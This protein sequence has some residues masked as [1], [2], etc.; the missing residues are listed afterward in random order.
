MSNSIRACKRSLF[1]WLLF[2]LIIVVEDPLHAQTKQI[3]GRV[4]LEGQ[5]L[6]S[7]RVAWGAEDSFVETD[8][9]GV[10]H[11]ESVCGMIRLNVIHADCIPLDTVLFL[12][13]IGKAHLKLSRRPRIHDLPQALVI[14]AR[15]ENSFNLSGAGHTLTAEDIRRMNPLSANQ[16]LRAV[17]GLNIVDEEGLGL[18]PNIGFRGLDPDR[19]RY[20]LVL[21]DGIPVSLG[22]YNEPELYYTPPID[23]MVGVEVLKGSAALA[24]GPRTIAGVVNYRTEDPPSQAQG[25]VNFQC[26]GGGFASLLGTFGNTV[27]KTGF[28]VTIL[29]KQTDDFGMLRLRI[30]DLNAKARWVISS[31]GVAGMKIGLYDEMSNANYIG[32]TDP[33]FRAGGQDYARLAPDDRFKV[34][35]YSISGNYSYRFNEHLQADML[36]YAYTTRRNW[37][38]QDFTYSALDSLG[39]MLQ[40]PVDWSGVTWGDTAI[41][42]GAIHM[43]N[44]TGNRNRSYRVAGADLRLRYQLAVGSSRHHWSLGLKGVCERAHELRINGS[45][46]GDTGGLL[47]DE[48]YRP[49]L[50]LSAYLSDRIEWRNLEINPGIRIE[51]MVYKRRILRGVYVGQVVDT[52]IVGGGK[53]VEI[54]PGVSMVYKFHEKLRVYGGIHKGFAPPRVKDAISTSGTDEQLDAE[55]SINYEV[56]VRAQY[57]GLFSYDVTFFALE[58]SNQVIPTSESAGSGGGVGLVNGGGTRSR[59]VELSIALESVRLGLGQW[60]MSVRSALTFTD[61][62]FSEDRYSGSGDDRINLKGLYLPYAPRWSSNVRTDLLH[63][64]GWGLNFTSNLISAQFTDVRNTIEPAANGQ[65]G[66]L[67]G[68]QVFDAGVFR[69]WNKYAF[70][71]S[72]TIRNLLDMRYA[73]TRR[74]Q[75]TRVGLPR[76]VFLSLSKSF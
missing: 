50:G 63:G 72:L 34:R 70:N 4:D 57:G 62:R 41:S 60:S 68:Y 29:R 27:G 42:G 65:S 39:R 24:Q 8:S 14:G 11:I 10:F 48:E 61:A 67:K 38:R 55:K 2:F 15:R 45:F 23:R 69:Q 1:G 28:R 40:P 16:V 22:P 56:G 59:G 58:F 33:M 71:V 18:R 44:S 9:R 53:L 75:G 13:Q 49:V 30:H 73:Y 6:K 51:H 46:P 26:G 21:E 31:K 66:L 37:C 36:L 35:R 52:N 7:A 12:D 43:R 32:L 3:I 54:L 17:P 74:P 64:A 76:M 5:A 19:S 25:R 20:V 47:T